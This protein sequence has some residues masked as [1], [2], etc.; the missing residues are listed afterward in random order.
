MK[1]IRLSCG[2]RGSLRLNTGWI[3]P[4]SETPASKM[5]ARASQPSERSRRRAHPTAVTTPRSMNARALMFW[6]YGTRSFTVPSRGP[7]LPDG[8]HLA[9]EHVDHLGIPLRACAVE[10]DRGGLV[11]AQARAVGA[12]VD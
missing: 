3:R 5:M 6:R 12:V 11:D 2:T 10:E 1:A 7:Q 9:H 4:T 8:R